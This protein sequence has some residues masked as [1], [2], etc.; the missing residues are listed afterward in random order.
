MMW[1]CRKNDYSKEIAELTREI[2]FDLIEASELEAKGSYY[3]ASL[4]YKRIEKH[5][6]YLQEFFPAKKH[7]E[8]FSKI[9]TPKMFE[10]Y[11]Q[12]KELMQDFSKNLPLKIQELNQK[13][14]FAK[15]QK[16]KGLV[17]Y[18]GNWV[19]EK[20][21]YAEMGMVKHQGEW[22]S[23]KKMEE[24]LYLRRKLLSYKNPIRRIASVTEKIA[25]EETEEVPTKPKKVDK[26]PKVEEKPVKPVVKTD[27]IAKKMLAKGYVQYEGRWMTPKEKFFL[28]QKEKGLLLHRGR[29]ITRAEYEKLRKSRDKR[30]SYISV[31]NQPRP[32]V[33]R[34]VSWKM[35]TLEFT[36]LTKEEKDLLKKKIRKKLLKTVLKSYLDRLE[37][38]YSEKYET[39][40]ELLTFLQKNPT[41][42]KNFWLAI[43]PRFD[44]I[45]DVIQIFDQLRRKY[46]KKIKIYYHLAIAIA[47]VWDSK[48]AISTSRYNCLWGYTKEQFGPL[49][50]YESVFAYFTNPKYTKYF[51]F[52]PNQLCWPLL[53]HLV[54]IALT[55]KE[56]EWVLE[57]YNKKKK[58]L[59]TLYSSIEYDTQRLTSRI[60]H[61]NPK[62]Y[63]MQNLASH[64]GIC[65][66]QAHLM[67]RIAKVFGVPAMKV[68]GHGKFGGG[69]AWAGYLAAK[70]G[71][72]LLKFTGRYQY[73]MFYTGNVFDPQ[74]RRETLD[75]YVAMVY[76]G[77]SKYYSRYIDAM[78]LTRIALKVYREDPK[79]SLKLTQHALD[80]NI[81][82]KR[83]WEL[84]LFHIRMKNLKKKHAVKWLNI[85]LSKLKNHPDLTMYGLKVFIGCVPKN[86]I[87]TRQSYY[88]KVFKVYKKRPDLQIKLRL[89]QC[90]ELMEAKRDSTAY[91]LAMQTC[92]QNA[93]EGGRIFP[94][95]NYCIDIAKR[96]NS[97][98][99]LKFHLKKLE[100]KFPKKRGTE[101]SEAYTK[102]KKL[103]NSL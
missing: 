6:K 55:P 56:C 90:K 74:T 94:L 20:E 93:Q 80:I 71:R 37:K 4:H 33:E 82:T 5:V 53:V 26:D 2:K 25:P 102:F 57:N 48:D 73:D 78:T 32:G 18:Q 65:G 15:K 51:I 47:V 29:W 92:F 40:K 70:G 38:Y 45:P 66:D 89:Q 60:P 75:R 76:D 72:P 64:K 61:L 54:D 23:K 36:I 96:K 91:N 30:P 7:N 22:V 3:G 98:A 58:R 77:I 86:K 11:P 50:S 12:F 79:L 43:S 97:M 24:N 88:N 16:A 17:F 67:T 81:Y 27:S 46:P 100:N 35:D 49:P 39:P 1:G 101:E 62:P 21:K 19:P 44:D 10:K 14:S 83:A 99:K 31:H 34:S 63:T 13:I 87:K 52:K 85:M 95:L 8:I 28:Q 9:C 41:I 68:G 84:L 42:R 59:H 103:V 69:H